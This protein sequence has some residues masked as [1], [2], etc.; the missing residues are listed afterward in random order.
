MAEA[1]PWEADTTSATL[2]FFSEDRWIRELA[3][4]QSGQNHLVGSGV[5][6]APLPPARPP[7]GP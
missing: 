3:L 7:G 2:D 4:R 1:F 5:F 6:G